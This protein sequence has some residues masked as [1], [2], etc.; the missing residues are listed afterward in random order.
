MCGNDIWKSFAPFTAALMLGLFAVS[1]FQKEIP[2]SENRKIKFSL[3]ATENNNLRI[4]SKPSAEYTDLARQNNTQGVVRLRVNFQ[5]N[6]EIGDVT[7]LN[8]LPDGL[9]E[10]AVE[11][12]K[13]MEFKP[14]EKNGEPVTVT[15]IVEYKFMIY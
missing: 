10:S 11:A 15:K 9:T 14:A 5:A 7:V 1:V 6:G 3:S 8:G 2:K 13:R 4:I 12:V